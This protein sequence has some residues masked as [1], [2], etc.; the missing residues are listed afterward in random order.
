MEPR[1]E[2]PQGVIDDGLVLEG[3]ASASSEAIPAFQTVETQ[4]NSQEPFRIPLL[5]Q[6]WQWDP[7]LELGPDFNIEVFGTYDAGRASPGMPWLPLR[8]QPNEQTTQIDDQRSSVAT[9]INSPGS[10]FTRIPSRKQSGQGGLIETPSDTGNQQ[11]IDRAALRTSLQYPP[12][13]IWLPPTSVLNRS[14]YTYTTKLWHLIPVVHLPSFMASRAHPLLLL[15]I[16]SIG[17]LAEGSAE[18]LEHAF[19]LYEGVQKSILV[20]W[21]SR[22]VFDPAILALIQAAVIGQTFAILSPKTKHLVAARSFHGTLCV[23]L[24]SF[25]DSMTAEVETN[26]SMQESESRCLV[27]K[28]QDWV[29][30]QTCIRVS[31]ALQCHDGEIA[32]TFQRRPTLRMAPTRTM[33]AAPDTAFLATSAEDW[34]RALSSNESTPGSI[35]DQNPQLSSLYSSCAVLDSILA[36]IIDLRL[37]RPDAL[38]IELDRLEMMVTEWNTKFARM[39]KGD[40][41]EALSIQYLLHSCFIHLLCDFNKFERFFGR[42]GELDT[43]VIRTHIREW[44]ATDTAKRCVVHA[45]AVAQLSARLRLNDVACLHLARIIYSAAVVLAVYAAFVPEGLASIP[46]A[47]TVRYAETAMM[48]NNVCD[49]SVGFS[50]HVNSMAE[51][52]RILSFSLAST[53]RSLGPWPNARRYAKTLDNICA[54]LEF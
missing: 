15:S 31:N 2:G 6:D 14:I 29:Q 49:F 38:Q 54:K 35:P 48:D 42:D 4:M 33:F 10:W 17:A 25:Q 45:L 39:Q 47:F 22:E 23:S 7:N 19:R 53:L 3:A 9:I 18:S 5:G 8:A 16:C 11:Y 26:A 52:C 44:A 36:E 21:N 24:E 46:Q 32:A 43:D 40:S 50:T 27:K 41:W 28:W 20:S 12:S 37:A 1:L 34:Q 51:H 13:E 30:M